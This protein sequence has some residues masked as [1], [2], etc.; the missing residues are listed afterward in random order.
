MCE[1]PRGL[2]TSR[3]GTHSAT[4][5][6]SPYS[7]SPT[8]LTPPALPLFYPSIFISMFLLPSL[9]SFLLSI[10]YPSL[11]PFTSSTIT[12]SVR[13]PSVHHHPFIQHLKD[14]VKHLLCASGAKGGDWLGIG[15]GDE[16]C[17]DPSAPFPVEDGDGY[18]TDHQDYCEVCQQGGEIILC[19]TCPRAY[20]L[21]CLDP[22]L[23]KAPAGEWSCPHCVS[24]GQNLGRVQPVPVI[25]GQD[26]GRC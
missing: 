11:Y 1:P 4:H 15:K 2:C 24:P 26:V 6:S 5:P 10:F 13:S 23:E 8:S 3:G 20:H 9:P 12:L 21:V 25:Q 22:E 7:Y 17:M 14:V 19:D 16:A 18:E